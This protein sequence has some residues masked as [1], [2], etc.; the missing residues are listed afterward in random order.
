[1]RSVLV[2][3]I[4][5]AALLLAGCGQGPSGPKGETGPVGPAGPPGPAGAAGWEPTILYLFVFII[6]EMIVFGFI[7]RALR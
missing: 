1:M 6:A 3:A 7:S 2:V 4:L 5:G